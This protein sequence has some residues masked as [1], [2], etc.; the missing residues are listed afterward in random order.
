MGLDLVELMMRIEKTFEL[1]I[2]DQ[3]A[4]KLVTPG[5]VIDY[6][7]S[8]LPAGPGPT[9]LSQRAFHRVRAALRQRFG[10]PRDTIRPSADLNTLLDSPDLD[11]TWR[12]LGDDLRAGRDWP[13]LEK[14]RYRLFRRPTHPLAE[15]VGFL[16]MNKP[17]TLLRSDEGWSRPLVASVVFPLVCD[18]L[19]L[20]PDMDIEHMHFKE[21]IGVD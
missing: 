14:L 15:V 8:R 10:L 3:V 11:V 13:W 16:T 21:D 9:C 1:T 17:R 5:L 7:T 20:K 18:E 4:V 6:L 2:P 12:L 19:G